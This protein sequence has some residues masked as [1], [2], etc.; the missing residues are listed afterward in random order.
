MCYFCIELT[1][2]HRRF[3]FVPY[4][5]IIVHDTKI[6]IDEN[7]SWLCFNPFRTARLQPTNYG[8]SYYAHIFNLPSRARAQ[9]QQKINNTKNQTKRTQTKKIRAN[10]AAK[11]L[12]RRK[13][14]GVQCVNLLHSMRRTKFARGSIGSAPRRSHHFVPGSHTDARTRREQILC[15][16]YI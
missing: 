1:Q 14:N 13:P 15:V 11:D 5:C 9:Y 4:G 2:I 8:R 16:S 10:N 7:I 3:A 12:A 6:S